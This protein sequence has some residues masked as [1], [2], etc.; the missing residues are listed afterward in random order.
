MKKG[1]EGSACFHKT[2]LGKIIAF[3]PILCV[4]NILTRAITQH[5]YNSEKSL[6]Q[7]TLVM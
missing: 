6:I 1:F 5:L 7:S 4:G 3:G 2:Y